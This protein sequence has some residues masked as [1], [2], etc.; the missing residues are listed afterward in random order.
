[1]LALPSLIPAKELSRRRVTGHGPQYRA[2]YKQ[3]P[4]S[5]VASSSSAALR[6]SVQQGMCW[7]HLQDTCMVALS[8]GLLL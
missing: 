4:A 1:M 3:H 6:P 2:G 7:M 5:N 8:Q